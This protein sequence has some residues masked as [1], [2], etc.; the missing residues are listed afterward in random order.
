MPQPKGKGT[1]SSQAGSGMGTEGTSEKAQR[2]GIIATA[3][4]VVEGK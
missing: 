4:L 2:V 3:F 1:E